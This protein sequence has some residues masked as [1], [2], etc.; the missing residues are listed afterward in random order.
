MGKAPDKALRDARLE[1]L[2][3]K[4]RA[5]REMLESADLP[6]QA[7]DIAIGAVVH[8]MDDSD[9]QAIFDL[10]SAGTYI[11]R[12]ASYIR[13][14]CRE[15]KIRHLREGSGEKAQYLIRREWMDDY[16]SRCAVDI[17]AI[18]ESGC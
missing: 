7:I 6:K 15:Q 14:L 11:S 8:S 4:I 13:K 10:K 3:P 16:L 2:L 1:K 9:G 17:P 18:H 5:M 12:K